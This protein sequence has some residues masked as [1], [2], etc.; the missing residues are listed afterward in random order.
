[1]LQIMKLS[2]CVIFASCCVLEYCSRQL[3]GILISDHFQSQ[4]K[5]R[6]TLKYSQSVKYQPG[7][8]LIPMSIT[9]VLG[10]AL[11]PLILHTYIH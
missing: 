4:L 11:A 8:V 9:Q 1:M 6:A 3:L 2:Y 5:T 7:Y 10:H